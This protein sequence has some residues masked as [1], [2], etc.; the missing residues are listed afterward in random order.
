M[1]LAPHGRVATPFHQNWWSCVFTTR[2]NKTDSNWRHQS[3]V[4]IGFPGVGKYF[5]WSS[6][7]C[8]ISLS[9]GKPIFTIDLRT[10]HYFYIN[11]MFVA[12]QM[13]HSWLPASS[14]QTLHQNWVS[15]VQMKQLF[16][17]D[18]N[19]VFFTHRFC[20]FVTVQSSIAQ[21]LCCFH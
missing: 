17:F 4:K 7:S 15:F 8:N 9:L 10:S 16:I 20:K 19:I 14:W 18:T 2:Y 1:S 12:K 21:Y 6:T 13:L 11:L 3:L 5:P